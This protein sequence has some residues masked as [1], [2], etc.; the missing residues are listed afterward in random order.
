VS[1]QGNWPEPDRRG[2][3]LLLPKKVVRHYGQITRPARNLLNQE[4]RRVFTG[5]SDAAKSTIAHGI[6]PELFNRG[7]RFYGLNRDNVRH[8]LNSDLEFSPQD[9]KKNIRRIVE[10]TNLSVDAGFIVLI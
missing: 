9:R 2:F 1:P 7:I 3:N 8:G 4:T 6:E 5:L 10:A